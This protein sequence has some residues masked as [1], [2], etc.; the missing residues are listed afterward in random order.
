MAHHFHPSLVFVSNAIYRN[1]APMVLNSNNLLPDLPH[2][3][4]VPN[5]GKHSSLVRYGKD[6]CRKK[7]LY[8]RP[9]VF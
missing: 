6:Y 2:R 1:G 8:Y 5:I 7:V 3:V 4:E 9:L